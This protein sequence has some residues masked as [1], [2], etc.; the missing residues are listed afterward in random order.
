MKL[1]EINWNPQER[2]LRQFGWLTLVALPLAGWLLLH[3]PNLLNLEAREKNILLVLLGIGIAAAVIGTIRP[4][5][6]KWVYIGACLAAL[7]IGLVVSELM[8]LVMYFGIF[9]PVALVFRV[10]GRDA[11]QRKIDRGAKTYWQK[12]VISGKAESYFR[13]S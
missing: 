9:L 2:I 7:P 6:L 11:L 12:K 8:M 5:L 10:I 1:V 3:R 13:Q 4:S